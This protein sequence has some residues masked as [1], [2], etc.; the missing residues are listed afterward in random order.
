[1]RTG[2][3]IRRSEWLTGSVTTR[4]RV[5]TSSRKSVS[6]A[7]PAKQSRKAHVLAGV[8]VAQVKLQAAQAQGVAVEK[9]STAA[10]ARATG[11]SAEADDEENEAEADDEEKAMDLAQ[12]VLRGLEIETEQ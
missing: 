2:C 10:P 4:A 12:F 5:H 11:A 1:M 8:T 9:A 6:T 3:R 7:S